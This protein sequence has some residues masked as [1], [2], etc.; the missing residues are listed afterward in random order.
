M[1]DTPVL[2]LKL[3]QLVQKVE[4]LPLLNEPQISSTLAKDEQRTERVDELTTKSTQ[5][6]NNSNSTNST[7]SSRT[8]QQFPW[9]QSI[10]GINPQSWW[11]TLSTH[12]WMQI[13]GLVRI[14][15]IDQPEASLLTPSQGYFLKENL[16]LRLL[17]AKLGCGDGFE[18]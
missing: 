10:K 8:E 11:E 18:D 12:I 7:P 3:D 6:A 16:K 17:N 15:R 13:K 5:T 4:V 2:L 14:T 9:A 1:L